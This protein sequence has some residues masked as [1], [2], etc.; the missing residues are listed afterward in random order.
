MIRGAVVIIGV[1]ARAAH[2]DYAFSVDSPVQ[3]VAD[4]GGE[5]Q[6]TVV[7]PNLKPQCPNGRILITNDQVRPPATNTVV[8]RDLTAGATANIFSTFDPPPDP[9]NTYWGTN[10]HDI[11]TLANGDVLLIWGAHSKA[12]VTPQPAWFPYTYKGTFGPGTRRGNMVWRSTDCGQTFQ[13]R[14]FI[15][16]ATLGDG[17]CALPSYKIGSATLPSPNYSNGGSDGQ[18]AQ[19]NLAGDTTYLTMSCRGWPRDPTKPGYVI[20]QATTGTTEIDSTYVLRS[21]DGG[22]VW[23]NLG[24]ITNQAWRYGVAQL[25]NGD[26]AVARL[27]DISFATKQTNGTYK[28]PTV[29]HP[30]PIAVG[31]DATTFVNNPKFNPPNAIGANLWASTILARVPGSDHLLITYPATIKDSAGKASHG[32]ELYFYDKTTK[33]YSTE[34]PILPSTHTTDNVAMHLNAIGTGGG[35]VLLYWYD[36]NATT[37]T[38]TLRGRVIYSQTEMSD[39]FNVAMDT[40]TTPHSFSVTPGADHWFGDYKTAGGYSWKGLSANGTA[41]YHYYPMWDQPDGTM[42]FSHVT[43]EKLAKPIVVKGS[44]RVL[45]P[46][47]KPAPPPVEVTRTLSER[48]RT[49]VRVQELEVKGR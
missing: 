46:K 11:V 47:W 25:D 45:I 48:E 24:K 44:N 2:A 29:E 27:N 36:V 32:H 9:A 23:T 15:D 7:A 30:L 31:W 21:T 3:S 35:P 14:T 49:L 16:P 19:V 4:S 28:M 40:A 37:N 20:N 13:Y 34:P 1:L 26:L 5:T 43:A 38:V 17:S 6:S 22:G 33:T 8:G 18:L 12:P 10:D 39:D 41:S 42:R